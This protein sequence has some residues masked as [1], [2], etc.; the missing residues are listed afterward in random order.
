MAISSEIM[1]RLDRI[2]RTR[3]WLHKKTGLD[4]K[5]IHDIC[6]GERDPKSSTVDIINE[7]LVKEERRIERAR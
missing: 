5:A 1:A 7:A 2:K 4:Y 3:Y 6:S